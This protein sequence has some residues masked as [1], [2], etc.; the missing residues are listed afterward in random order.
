[1]KLV[2]KVVGG[3]KVLVIPSVYHDMFEYG[4]T[5]DGL[6]CIRTARYKCL[7]IP[8]YRWDEFKEDVEYE[9]SVTRKREPRNLRV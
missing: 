8:A 6:K 5:Y 4:E 1:M 9:I 3:K 2:C 7:L